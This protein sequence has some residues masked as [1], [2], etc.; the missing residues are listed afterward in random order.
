MHDKVV[1]FN[2]TN[3]S[4]TVQKPQRVKMINYKKGSIIKTPKCFGFVNF[5]T[6]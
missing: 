1:E 6:S 5:E 3:I 2:V 4:I